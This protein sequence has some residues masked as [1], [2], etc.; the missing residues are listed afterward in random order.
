MKTAGN[1]VTEI[2]PEEVHGRLSAVNVVR[3]DFCARFV[4]DEV[5]SDL[6]GAG[7]EGGH[8]LSFALT[9]PHIHAG[10][11]GLVTP[12]TWSVAHA[13]MPRP[14]LRRTLGLLLLRVVTPAVV[15]VRC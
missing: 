7:G 4:A 8:R 5:C 3:D 14:R 11:V 2:V 10:M 15:L 6:F 12:P 9:R 1:T 13:R